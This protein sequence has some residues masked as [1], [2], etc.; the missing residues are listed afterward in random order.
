MD[1]DKYVVDLA[2]KRNP[3]F[4]ILP[5]ELVYT[6]LQAKGFIRGQIERL[7]NDIFFKE[8]LDIKKTQRDNRKRKQKIPRSGRGS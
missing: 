2:L 4:K 7:Y 1:Y 8:R 3:E 6:V 5:N